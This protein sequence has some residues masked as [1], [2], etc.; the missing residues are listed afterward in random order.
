MGKKSKLKR[1]ARRRG[2][3]DQVA[4]LPYRLVGDRIEILTI[5]SRRRKRIIV[6]KGWPMDGK[7]DAVAAAIEADEEAGAK[8]RVSK[9][10]WGTFDYIKEIDAEPISVRAALFPLKVKKLK[11]RWKEGK[12]RQRQWLSAEDAFSKLDDPGLRDLVRRYTDHL[13]RQL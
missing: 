4:A 8:G 10:A 3:L 13:V 11:A 9:D 12:E 2:H 6:P 1:L 5:T 7:D